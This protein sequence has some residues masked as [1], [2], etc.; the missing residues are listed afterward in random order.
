LVLMDLLLDLA[1][2]ASTIAYAGVQLL[3][4]AYS[5]H[6]WVVLWRAARARRRRPA[7]AAP[8]R[9]RVPFVTV[10]LPV[11]NERAVV[12]RLVDAVSALDWP[13]DRLEIQVLDDS[14]D[15]TRARAARAVARAR[16][17][18]VDVIHRVRAG[19]VGFKAGALAAGLAEARGD[20]VAVF[21]ADFVPPADFLR[22]GI[23][24]F[25]DPEVGMVQA[26]WTHLNRDRSLLTAAQATLLDAHFRLEHRTRADA[27]LFFNFNGTAG[28]WRRA[29]IADAGG[30]SSDTLTEDLDLSYRAQRRGWR[31][32][33]LED[34][35]APAELPAHFEALQAQQHRWAKGSIQT[36][37]KVLPGLLASRRLPARV[38]V[39]AWFHLTN[40]AAYPLLLALGALL[41]PVL[42]ARPAAVAP[43]AVWTMH[44]LVLGFGLVPVAAFLALGRRR[45]GGTRRRVARD[46]AAALLLGVGLSWTNTRAVVEGLRGPAGAWRRTP[47]TGDDGAA[48]APRRVYRV[49]G[50]GGGGVEAGLAAYFAGVAGYALT[51]GPDAARAVPF[52]LW[53][54]LGFAF[55]AAS[56]RRVRAG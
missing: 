8:R 35:E 49:P 51:A 54:A 22:R 5:S 32:V 12:E 17:R 28:I 19:R 9:E 46:V 47:K 25:D 40:N 41:L 18:G 15:D 48:A 55:V 26:C 27:G 56:A 10:Q 1:R 30:W 21:D 14:T 11:Y 2:G 24:P 42:L 37:R 39:E 52:V 34:L 53:L 4:A 31:F 3:L 33:F 13:R 29:C 45:A 20:F 6:R 16:S 23:L 50:A 43:W 38:K 7:A 36:A 44:G